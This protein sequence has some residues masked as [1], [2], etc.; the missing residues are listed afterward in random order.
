MALSQFKAIQLIQVEAA[1]THTTN[2]KVFF[3]SKKSV[4][5]FYVC[6]TNTSAGARTGY[7]GVFKSVQTSDSCKIDEASLRDLPGLSEPAAQSGSSAPRV[8]GPAAP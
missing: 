2:S 6:I 5:A 7:I 1:G 4:L 8:P 3:F